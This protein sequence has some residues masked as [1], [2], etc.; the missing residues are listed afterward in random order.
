M[1]QCWYQLFN[2]K[3]KPQD[4]WG[5]CSICTPS[6]ENEKCKGFIPVWVEY[7]ELKENNNGKTK[8]RTL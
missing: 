4:G 6:P 2:K 7:F 5:D 1:R 8:M 3:P